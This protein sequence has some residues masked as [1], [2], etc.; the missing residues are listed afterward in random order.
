MNN[1]I[2]IILLGIAIFG[3]IF[4]ITFRERNLVGGISAT[5]ATWSAV[6]YRVGTR[7]SNTEV[8]S[9]SRGASFTTGVFSSTLTVSGE[10]NLDTLVQGG[11]VTSIST[12][13][14][15]YTLTAAQVC[16]SAVI[17]FTN[18]SATATTITLPSTTT[19]AADCLPTAGDS[20]VFLFE[21]A[22]TSSVNYTLAAGTGITLLSDDSN[23]DVIG[24]N[25]WG[26][27]QITNV[28]SSEFTAVIRPFTDAD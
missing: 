5:N 6:S 16:N 19:L 2:P 9:S 15:T 11:D 28:R 17:S 23:G 22:A 21:N 8:I 4:G 20:K 12:T 24:Q 18:L 25:G 3:I 1:T 14:A 26:E 13:S 7:A 27:V 10:S